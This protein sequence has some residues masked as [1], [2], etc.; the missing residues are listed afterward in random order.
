MPYL[1][2]STAN[3][4]GHRPWQTR[5]YTGFADYSY[6]KQPQNTILRG[7]QSMRPEIYKP[8]ELPPP[9]V[10][11]VTVVTGSGRVISRGRR[12]RHMLGVIPELY[13]VDGVRPIGSPILVRG[14][15]SFLGPPTPAP[16]PAQNFPGVYYGYPGQTPPVS[17]TPLPSPVPVYPPMLPPTIVPPVPTP[18]ASSPDGTVWMLPGTP[19]VPGSPYMPAP[20]AELAPPGIA[21]GATAAVPSAAPGTFMDWFQSQTWIAGVPNGYIAAG[22]V[23]AIYF[24]GKRRGR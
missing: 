18:V 21:P 1:Q 24:M 15:V 4:Y 19:A 3:P 17:P 6:L 9:G 2:T 23:L 8:P 20:P 11:A 10:G 5:L 14:P 12:R 22:A 16:A 13:P 7:D